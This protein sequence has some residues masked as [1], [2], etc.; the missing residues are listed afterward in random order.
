MAKTKKD[1]KKQT[2]GIPEKNPAKQSVKVKR[3]DSDE[4]K[5]KKRISKNTTIIIVL[6]VVAALVVGVSVLAY[7]GVISDWI[8]SFSEEED[9]DDDDDYELT[10]GVAA[11]VDG[12]NITEDTVSEYIMEIREYYSLDDDDDWAY[13]LEYYGYDC[14]DYRN[15]VID[16]YVEQILIAEAIQEYDLSV[17]E[18]EIDEAWDEAASSYDSEETFLE[19]IEY[20]GYDEDE[21]RDALEED[22]LEE[23]LTEAVAPEDDVTDDELIE[24]INDNLTDYNYSRRSSHILIEVEDT[25]DEDELEEAEIEATAALN[26]IEDGELTFDEAVEEYSDDSSKDDGGDVGWDCLS[27]FVDEYQDALDELEVGEISDITLS[28]YGY[29]IIKC[30]D[31]FYIEDEVT[32]LDEVPEEI[33]EDA[34]DAMTSE[35]VS[36]DYEEWYEE[37]YAAADIEIFDMPEDVPYYVEVEEDDEDE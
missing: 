2:E 5:K 6:V 3:E 14:E 4:K 12:V 11:T 25:D 17:T 15:D 23:K 34:L 22:L 19:I 37:Y 7:T 35:Q 16:S 24:Y 21:Y 28:D 20:M 10:G 31:Y 27:D 32:S 18:E 26:Q 33:Q 8:A 30:T 9:D 36:E 29:H 1:K 13:Y